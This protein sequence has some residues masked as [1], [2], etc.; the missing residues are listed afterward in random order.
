MFQFKYNECPEAQ[1]WL[2]YVNLTGL[3]DTHIAG[4]TLFLDV[5]TGVFL[6]EISIRI[7]GLRKEDHLH[8]CR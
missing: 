6:E 2:V 1:W 3:K 4:K 7:H 5:T 8:H